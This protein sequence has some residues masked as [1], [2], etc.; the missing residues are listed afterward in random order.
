MGGTTGF[1][2]AEF[3]YDQDEQ[4]LRALGEVHMDLQAPEPGGKAPPAGARADLGFGQEDAAALDPAVIHV[5]TSGLV[6]MRK[7]GIAA[8]GEQTEFRYGG[9]TCTSHGAEFDSEHG[10]APD[11]GGREADGADEEGTV[12]LDGQPCRA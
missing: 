3:S 7:L 4:V 1:T 5:R 9:V 6:Y 11:A 12:H 8:T 10:A 2:A